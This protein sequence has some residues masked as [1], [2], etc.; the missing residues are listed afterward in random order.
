MFY[1][2]IFSPEN[3]DTPLVW[4]AEHLD[5]TKEPMGAPKGFSSFLKYEYI[6]MRKLGVE[7]YM[8]KCRCNIEI[9][10][11]INM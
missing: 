2:L 10:V 1:F 7:K 8:R 9:E 5:N 3:K 4:K 6:Y 11:K